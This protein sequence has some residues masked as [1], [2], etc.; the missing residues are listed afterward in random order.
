MGERKPYGWA[1]RVKE[2]LAEPSANVVSALE[3]HLEELLGHVAAASQ[4][5]AWVEEERLMRGALRDLAVARSDVLD[6][7]V[8]FEYELHLEGGRRP[9]VVLHAGE[10]LFVVEFKQASASPAGAADQVIAY[11]RDLAEVPQGVTP[12]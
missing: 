9:D 3:A 2:L 12:P 1:G 5:N 8:T 10:K 6:W 11:S 4:S 7:G